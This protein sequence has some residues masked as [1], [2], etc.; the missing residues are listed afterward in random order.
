MC[1]GTPDAL[2]SLSARTFL[3]LSLSY[4]T[5]QDHTTNIS[6]KGREPSHASRAGVPN[7]VQNYKHGQ[8]M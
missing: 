1:G 3:V 6:R 4:H 5:L 8:N 2:K 7:N